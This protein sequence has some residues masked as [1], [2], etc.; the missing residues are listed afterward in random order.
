MD[1]DAVNFRV[2]I[3]GSDFGFEVFFVGG[4]VIDDVDTDVACVFDFKVDIFV[5]NRVVVIADD[6][7]GGFWFQASDLV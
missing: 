6:E 7:E 1:D 4:V 3:R 2:G 5:N